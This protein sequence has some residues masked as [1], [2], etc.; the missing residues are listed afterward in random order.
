MHAF[1]PFLDVYTPIAL[2]ITIAGF[3]HKVGMHVVRLSRPPTPGLAINL[4]DAPPKLGWLAAAWDVLS[5]PV[6]RFNVRANPV[7]VWGVVF[8][9][10]G[11]ITIITGYALSTLLVCGYLA[12][13]LPIPDVSTGIPVSYNISYSNVFAIIFGNGEPLQSM[14]LF[15][16]LAGA[17]RLVT[18]L[19]VLS[20]LFG[21]SLILITHI[22]G[23]GG[24]IVGDIDK[25]AKKIRI[26]GMFTA[27][28]LVITLVVYTIIW[29]EI[30][31]R[32]D[33]VHG[34]VYLHSVIGV[35]LILMMPYT[36]LFH[37]MYFPVSIFYA[38]RRRRERCIA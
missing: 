8:Y 24:A 34:I 2:L 7:L 35:T 21:N 6:T 16:P 17:F 14:F 28:H 22:L 20:A 29:T 27:S 18:W 23:R 10:M 31:S 25:A 1:I 26:K 19:A 12:F 4:L 38:A 13:G 11:I 15:G 36:Y 3:A 32:I 37:M 30:L 33:A 5:F 9:H